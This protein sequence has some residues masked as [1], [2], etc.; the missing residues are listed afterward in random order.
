MQ[1]VLLSTKEVCAIGLAFTGERARWVDKTSKLEKN[2]DSKRRSVVWNLW[3]AK[4]ADALVAHFKAQG[5]INEITRTGMLC[6]IHRHVSGG[7]YVRVKA[8]IE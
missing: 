6:D 7:E 1:A 8:L 2:K 3:D 5:V 4:T